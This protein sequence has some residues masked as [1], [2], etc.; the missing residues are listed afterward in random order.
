MGKIEDALDAQPFA[1]SRY[2]L[3]HSFASST[4]NGVTIRCANFAVELTYHSA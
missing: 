3:N 4:V 1:K 2:N